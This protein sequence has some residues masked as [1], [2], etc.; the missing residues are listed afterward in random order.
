[1]KKLWGHLST[2]TKHKISVTILC[3]RCG[4]YRQGILHDLS[5]YSPIEFFSGVRYYQ[6]FRSPID[7]E[8]EVK[9][10]SLGWLHHKGRNKH[11]WEYWLDNGKG[12]MTPVQMPVTYVIEMVCDRIAAS[13]TY[14]KDNYHDDSALQYFHNGLD[15]VVIHPDTKKLT[16]EILSYLAVNGLDHTIRFIRQDIRKRSAASS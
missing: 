3:F 10:Y 15:Y 16:E 1:M 7:K 2:I 14:M 8:K 4:L 13:K 5:K 12:T 6:G 11:H 9:G